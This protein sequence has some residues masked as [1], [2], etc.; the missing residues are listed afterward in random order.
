MALKH[1][2]CVPHS[3]APTE[4]HIEGE[5]TL[6]FL[7]MCRCWEALLATSLQSINGSG[8]PQSPGSANLTLRISPISEMG[9]LGSLPHGSNQNLGHPDIG[10]V[11]PTCFDGSFPGKHHSSDLIPV[12]SCLASH[13]SNKTHV[14]TT[15]TCGC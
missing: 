15:T 7:Y 13:L 14:P 12:L 2:N 5:Q 10:C 8:D 3:S 4:L 9:L 6:T 1:M 11:E